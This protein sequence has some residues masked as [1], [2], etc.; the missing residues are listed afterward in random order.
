MND[1]HSEI[2]SMPSLLG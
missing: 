2:L 1:I